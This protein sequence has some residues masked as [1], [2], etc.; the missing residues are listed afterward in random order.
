MFRAIDEALAE[1]VD[2]VADDIE[3]ATLAVR[4]KG[5]VS[6][7]SD[8]VNS[9]FGEAMEVMSDELQQVAKTI[10]E[11]GVLHAIGEDLQGVAGQLFG[12]QQPPRRRRPAK[13]S[14]KEDLQGSQDYISAQR[15]LAEAAA[16]AEA[17]ARAAMSAVASPDRSA[18]GAS[19]SKGPAPLQDQILSAAEVMQRLRKLRVDDPSN[20][21]CFDCGGLQSTE[22]TSSS[23]GIF[24]CIQCCGRHR[25]LG[26]HISRVRSCRI[27]SWTAKQLQVFEHGGN[28]RLGAFFKA[29]KVS[30]VDPYARYSTEAAGWYRDAWMKNRMSG[31]EVPLPPRGLVSGA[32]TCVAG[33]DSSKTERPTKS[34]VDLMNMP[35]QQ[36]VEAAVLQPKALDDLLS[37]D[38]PLHATSRAS[39]KQ[40]VEDES[41]FDPNA[42]SRPLPLRLPPSCKPDLGI[43]S[44]S[45]QEEFATWSSVPTPRSAAV[46]VATP[47]GG[48]RLF[49]LMT[50][51]EQDT[52]APV[53]DGG[54]PKKKP[55]ASSGPAGDPFAECRWC[56]ETL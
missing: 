3:A 17:A 36:A 8:E 23:F 21:C 51:A 15:E 53:R 11:K 5:L 25:R 34:Q 48:V 42:S 35:N 2:Y 14:S 30:D 26:T 1:A 19:S 31:L 43:G 12:S 27:D 28:G 45:Q 47:T 55:G 49:D 24:L 52:K 18:A 39:A 13:E 44:G 33:S 40:P 10:N 29:N 38:S 20:S 50:V 16:A 46:K 7:I 41:P 6:A 4:K 32:C 37:L 22:W 56:E 54:A 9:S